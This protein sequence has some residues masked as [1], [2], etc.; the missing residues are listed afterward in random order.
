MKDVPKYCHV[1][2][3][4]LQKKYVLNSKYIYLFEYRMKLERTTFKLDILKTQSMNYSTILMNKVQE[5]IPI[6]EV[7]SF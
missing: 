7:R 4:Q 3:F 6:L 5:I 2:N 1:K